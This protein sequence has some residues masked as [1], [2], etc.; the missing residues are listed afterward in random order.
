MLRPRLLAHALKLFP[1]NAVVTSCAVLSPFLPTRDRWSLS[2]GWRRPTRLEPRTP[3]T[4][5]AAAAC[6]AC[7]CPVVALQLAVFAGDGV[8]KQLPQ[9]LFPARANDE[10]V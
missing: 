7:G 3:C 9:A 1:R 10:R 6:E 8:S 4:Y 5:G 2:T